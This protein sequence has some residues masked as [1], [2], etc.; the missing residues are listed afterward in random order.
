M[1]VEPI[2]ASALNAD[3][4]LKG[5]MA[6]K[7]NLD[8]SL[9]EFAESERKE[10]I[11]V[12]RLIQNGQRVKKWQLRKCLK[13]DLFIIPAEVL[14][15]AMG[16]PDND[17]SS[18]AKRH[19]FPNREGPKTERVYDLKKVLKALWEMKQGREISVD[20]ELKK[21]KIIGEDIKNKI[22]L[23]QYIKKE[24]AEERCVR[25]LTAAMTRIRY[26]VK[27]AAPVLVGIP[28]AQDAEDVMGQ[29]FQEAL[30]FLEE[31]ANNKEWANEITEEPEIEDAEDAGKNE[32]E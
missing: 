27:K 15:P 13:E 14:A 3:I 32:K 22:R 17:L 7:I 18:L 4:D 5:K 31:E 29:K 8:Y 12:L 9:S 21:K 1:M 6:K 23:R 19:I 2:F 10:V 24:R 26:A 20:T 25:I 28:S 30:Q 11:N 16:I